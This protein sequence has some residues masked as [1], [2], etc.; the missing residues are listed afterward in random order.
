M[1][2]KKCCVQTPNDSAQSQIENMTTSLYALPAIDSTQLI[3]NP[4]I[5]LIGLMSPGQNIDVNNLLQQQSQSSHGGVNLLNNQNLVQIWLNYIKGIQ[6]FNSFYS[7]QSNEKKR[8]RSQSPP[9]SIPSSSSSQSSEIPLS[10]FNCEPLDLSVNKKVKLE[11]QE[12][13]HEHEPNDDKYYSKKKYLLKNFAIE[14]IIKDEN[15]NTNETIRFEDGEIDETQG[16][17]T[18][19]ADERSLNEF[20]TENADFSNEEQSLTPPSSVKIKYETESPMSG[21]S[22][23]SWKGHI[24]QGSDMY[25]CDQCDKM[26]SKQSSLARHKYEHSGIRP[27]VCDICTKAFKH[28]HHLAEHKRLHTGEKPFGCNTCGKRFSHSGSY[29]QH[30]NHRFKYCR[31]YREEQLKLENLESSF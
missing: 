3:N 26:F 29:S 25:A 19:S 18:C 17:N 31:P 10:T 16:S 1:T 8:M 12:N 28:K 9:L 22:R 27:F 30:M 20:E 7:Y 2:S 24:I 15:N 11:E 6:L 21:T 13:E 14:T 23:R 5:S 4:L